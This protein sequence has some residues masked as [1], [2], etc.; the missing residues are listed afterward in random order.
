MIETIKTTPTDI[1]NSVET[2][3]VINLNEVYVAYDVPIPQF[4]IRDIEPKPK[5]EIPKKEIQ[6]K[7]C[8]NCCCWR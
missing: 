5:V 3:T 8:Y 7:K 6:K 4:M 2:K 1:T